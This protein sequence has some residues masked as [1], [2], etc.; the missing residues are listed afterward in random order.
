MLHHQVMLSAGTDTSSGTMEWALSL[1]LNSPS[2]LAKARD[3]IDAQ[4]GQSRVI[5]ESDLAQLPYL[6]CIVY[7]TLRMFPLA[8]LLAP[9]ESSEDCTVGGFCVPRGTMLMVNVWAIQNDPELWEE[10]EQFRPERFQG[11]QGG[12][13]GF[14]FWPFG[15]GRR[16]CPG[17]GL[18]MRMV[19]LG[20]GL[21]IQCF[22][23]ERIGEDMVDMSEGTGLTMPKAQPLLGNCRPRSVMVN[24]L[25]QL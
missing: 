21:L 6:R 16:G 24:V 15:S 8:P 13:D 12:R 20:L 3:E 25:S 18:A 22:E 5:E 19:G 4:V 23:W 17:E 7:E 9:H 2:G 11:L 14:A 10:P 1:L